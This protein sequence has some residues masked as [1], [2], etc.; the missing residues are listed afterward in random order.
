MSIHNYLP[1]SDQY[2]PLR[3]PDGGEEPVL[4]TKDSSE[5]NFDADVPDGL[6]SACFCIP[7]S[8]LPHIIRHGPKKQ[9]GRG[10]E[11]LASAYGIPGAGVYLYT[12]AVD[13]FASFEMS[14]VANIKV[15][16]D[17]NGKGQTESARRLVS[18]ERFCNDGTLPHLVLVHCFFRTSKVLWKCSGG[19]LS[20]T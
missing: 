13:A 4:A 11:G 20:G 16:A 18:G 5:P 1:C 2:G 12:A 9:F 10:A 19:G 3:T 8:Q 17:P 6:V 7:P 15:P 14:V